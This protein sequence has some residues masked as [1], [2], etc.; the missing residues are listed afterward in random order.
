MKEIQ[1]I[2]IWQIRPHPDN[3]R[4]E[5][6]DLSELAESIRANGIF[7]NLTVVPGHRMTHDEWKELAERFRESPS[8]EIRVQM[9]RRVSDEGYTVII[10]HRRL[11]ASK[12]AG[13]TE[14]PCVVTEM[15]QREQVQTML[16]ENMQRSDL[17]VYEQAQGFQMM[18]DLGSSVEEI[19]EKSGFSETTVRR[20][21]KM[22]E[23]NQETLKEV[24]DRQLSLGDFDKLAQIEDIKKRNEV[25]E[26]IGTRDFS[27][28]LSRALSVQTERKN[29]PLVKAW[30]K[31]VGAK[32]LSQNDT[33]GSNYEPYPGCGYYIFLSKWGE[34]GNKPPK[35]INEQIYYY[36]DNSSLKLYRKKQKAKPAQKSDSELAKEKAVREAR[37]SLEESAAL[38]Y[39]LRK[40][41]VETL[42]LTNKNRA[43][44]LYGALMAHLLESIDYNSPDRDAISAVFGI[45]TDHYDPKRSEK[46]MD[47]IGK[48]QDKDIPMLIYAGFGDNAKQMCCANNYSKAFP[49]YEAQPK[50]TVIYAWLKRLGYE[51][52]TEEI[53]LLNGEHAGYHAREAFEE[54][55]NEQS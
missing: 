39:D 53:Q 52:S 48:I 50:L 38:A 6:G 46:L 21:V 28:N 8:E 25:L 11:A 7:Q 23:L 4:K 42:T 15:T 17:T 16:L 40:K 37:K 24:S 18:L 9:N 12:L 14:V 36:L 32:E 29:R 3:P 27:A 45:D 10:G 43:D 31:E 44:I 5:L 33:W 34:D 19:A 41:F 26:S 35:T 49:D 30:L 22:M 20:R 2:P 51:M 1:M 54:G 55:N 13:L 47:G